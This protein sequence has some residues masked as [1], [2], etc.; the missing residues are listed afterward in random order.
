[1]AAVWISRRN[2]RFVWVKVLF[3]KRCGIG[4]FRHLLVIKIVRRRM[5]AIDLGKRNLVIIERLGDMAALVKQPI[6]PPVA[7][8]YNLLDCGC[9]RLAGG[10]VT[11]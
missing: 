1:L 7:T 5:D 2:A 4:K 10:L 6:P 3:E 9:L 8:E 11:H